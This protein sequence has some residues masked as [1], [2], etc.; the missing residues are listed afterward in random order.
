[1]GLAGQYN[2]P[3]AMYGNQNQFPLTQSQQTAYPSLPGTLN[4]Q[5]PYSISP[6]STGAVGSYS[7]L[8]MQQQPAQQKMGG[9]NASMK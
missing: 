7:P 1:M 6:Q 4:S 5:S 8:T 3:F 2:N 9:S